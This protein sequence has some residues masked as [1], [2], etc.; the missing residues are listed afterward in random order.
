MAVRTNDYKEPP[1]HKAGDLL[2]DLLAQPY[3]PRP[4]RAPA[5]PRISHGKIAAGLAWLGACYTTYLAVV[6]LQPG[7]PTQIAIAVAL[8]LQFVLTAAERPLLRG[9]PDLF[10][11]AVLVLDAAINAGGI[12]P[13][14]KNIGRTPTAAMLTDV[15]VAAS[16]DVWPAVIVALLFGAIIAAAPEALWRMRD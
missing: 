8:V 13:A 14:L 4:I 7:T 6:S 9:R 2:D 1:R 12:Y 10:T 15:G 5:L 3:D 16:M 11:G